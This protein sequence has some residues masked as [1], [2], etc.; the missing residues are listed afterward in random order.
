MVVP[1][2][3]DEDERGVDRVDGVEPPAEADLEDG[4]VDTGVPKSDGGEGGRQL[5]RRGLAGFGVL[6]GELVDAVA[7]ELDAA[8]KGLLADGGAV[9]AD[10]FAVIV[11]VRLAVDAGA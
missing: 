9:D 2:R 11:E 6:L 4:V 8:R 1:D 10:T 7:K 5:E 3:R